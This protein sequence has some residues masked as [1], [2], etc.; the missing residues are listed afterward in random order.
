[1]TKLS[2]DAK[3]KWGDSTA[4]PA[5]VSLAQ[6]KENEEQIQKDFQRKYFDDFF[7]VWNERFSEEA[8]KKLIDDLSLIQTT[9]VL[10]A[11]Q[12]D[13]DLEILKATKSRLENNDLTDD[14]EYTLELKLETPNSG[15]PQIIPLIRGTR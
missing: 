11:D 4:T 8:V 10:R 12:L 2:K 7:K 3:N 14:G 1:M 15:S 9:P 13:S 6:T 5:S